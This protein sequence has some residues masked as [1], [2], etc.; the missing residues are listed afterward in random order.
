MTTKPNLRIGIDVGGTNTDAVVV[1]SSG[2]VR[3]RHK[4][5][6]TPAVFD[7]VRAALEAVLSAVDGSAIGQVML[8]TT[9]PLNA[10]IRRSGLGRVGVLRIG[11][12]ATLSVPPLAGWPN[13][14][15]AALRGPAAIVRGGHEYS[16]VECGPLD[17]AAI[18][19]FAKQCE[20]AVDAIAVTAMSSPINPA[21][22]RRAAE[23]LR[24]VLGRDIAVTESRDVGGIGLLEREN[25]AILNSAL[26][27][28]GRH[29][30]ESLLQALAHHEMTPDVY[31]TQND[32]TLLTVE[33]A[34]RRPV[35]TIG[36]GP[37]NS[38]RGAA[39]LTG[40][41]D[42]VV[43][44]VGGTSTDVGLLVNGFPRES[45]LAVEI[46][47]VRTNYRMPDLIAVGLGG[48][49]IV[50]DENG[51]RIGPDS[52]G[53]RLAGEAIVFGGSTLT[54]SDVSVAAGRSTI[55]EREYLSRL[56]R[57]LVRR[58]LESIDGR[59]AAL[60]DRIKAS[61][62]PQPLVAVGGGAHLV[63]DRIEGID[64]VHRHEHADVANAIGAAIAEASGSV[65]RTF[66]YDEGGRA[67]CLEQARELAVEQAVRAGA[68]PVR[69]RITALTEVP[70]SYMPGTSVRVQAKAV[71]PLLPPSRDAGHG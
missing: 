67:Y 62:G 54:L 31:L 48:G 34:I 60:A 40:L 71:G 68:D 10:I 45:A 46:G 63:P 55:G 21:H 36:S 35:L 70:M 14:L 2:T 43:M 3:A 61:R 57:G 49:T 13:D 11:A 22:E 53:Y 64:M 52:V 6:T 23:L 28:V 69:V 33:E 8:G 65:D 7:G 5:P 24:E 66:S 1:D 58:A 19:D 25:S 41:T 32:G 42:A 47:G 4:A 50:T 15:V 30:V 9:H 18:L 26:V 12:P 39:Y 38:M 27:G 16:G 56:D 29:V 51:M 37:T 20:G 17:E 59:F 44:D